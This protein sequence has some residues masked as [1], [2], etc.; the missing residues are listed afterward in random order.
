MG[1]FPLAG[2]MGVPYATLVGGL[3]NEG[4]A[5]AMAWAVDDTC[6]GSWSTAKT[7]VAAF[8]TSHSCE[9]RY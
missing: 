7:D 8:A 9:T 5:G 4:Y 3:W 1:E 6:C 2:L